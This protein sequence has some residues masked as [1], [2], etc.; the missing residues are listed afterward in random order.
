MSSLS[1][2][3]YPDSCNS[4]CSGN[5]YSDEKPVKI[6]KNIEEEFQLDEEINK[7]LEI[8]SKKLEKILLKNKAMKTYFKKVKQSEKKFINKDKPSISIFDYLRRIVYY[9][10]IEKSTIVLSLIYIM[11]LLKEGKIYLNEYNIHRIIFAALIAA[12]K[13]NEDSIHE[14]K[15]L[16]KVAGISEKEMVSIEICFLDL[17]DFNFFVNEK[18]Y[19]DFLIELFNEEWNKYILFVL[20]IFYFDFIYKAI[21]L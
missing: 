18:Y 6:T 15:Y 9:T 20:S 10:Q 1:L 8:Y 4:T 13:Y 2:S 16:A 5:S 12:Y 7:I 3:T 14:N 21:I 11:R 17:M 19:E